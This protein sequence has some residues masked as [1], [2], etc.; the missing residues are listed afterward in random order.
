MKK[1]ISLILVLAMCLGMLSGCGGTNNANNAINGNAG[2]ASNAADPSGNTGMS[3]YEN[4]LINGGG[5]SD[6]SPEDPPKEEPP[7][8]EPEKVNSKA[9]SEEMRKGLTVSAEENAFSR[10]GQLKISEL[11][12]GKAEDLFKKLNASCIPVLDAWETDA[13]LSKD[14]ELPGTY[15]CEYDLRSAEIPEDLWDSLTVV[16]IGDDGS[17]NE[18]ACEVKDGKLIWD[19]S[20]NSI[21]VV[22]VALWTG[23]IV[24]EIVLGMYAY[25]YYTEWIG[26]KYIRDGYE[27]VKL[28]NQDSDFT[29]YYDRP[30]STKELKEMEE[31]IKKKAFEEAREWYKAVGQ[32]T[33]FSFLFSAESRIN[34]KA[35]QLM[36]EMKAEDK[37]Y[38]AALKAYNTIPADVK[39]EIECVKHARDFIRW[40][41]KA[42]PLGYKADVVLASTYSNHGEQIS[43]WIKRNYIVVRRIPASYGDDGEVVVEAKDYNEVLTTCTHEMFH[44][45]SAK[46]YSSLSFKNTTFAEM[47]ALWAQSEAEE[48]FKDTYY[49][50]YSSGE[51]PSETAEELG[52]AGMKY[53][54]LGLDGMPDDSIMERLK[55]AQDKGYA[56]YAFPV[57]IKNRLKS[58]VTPWDMSIKYDEQWG[59]SFEKVFT[60]TFGISASE[61]ETFWRLFVRE[62]KTKLAKGSDELK[63]GE[64]VVFRKDGKNASSAA[65]IFTSEGHYRVPLAAADYSVRAS[66]FSILNEKSAEYLIVEDPE[67][68]SRIPLLEFVMPESAKKTETKNGLVVS[69]TQGADDF[70]YILAVQGN[71]GK[72]A[73]FYDVYPIFAPDAPKAAADAEKKGVDVTLPSALAELP[74]AKDKV[75]DGI[76]ITIKDGETTLQTEKVPFSEFEKGKDYVANVPFSSKNLPESVDITIS[77]YT[78]A[79]AGAKAYEGPESK[80]TSVR[81]GAEDI[82]WVEPVTGLGIT[83]DMDSHQVEALLFKHNVDQLELVPR[84]MEQKIYNTYTPEWQERKVTFDI[85]ADP[86]IVKLD[87]KTPYELKQ[88]VSYKDLGLTIWDHQIP[89]GYECDLKLNDLCL[90][91]K[92]LGYEEKPGEV[93]VLFGTESTVTFGYHY[94]KFDS[95]DAAVI[96]SYVFTQGENN[97]QVKYTNEMWYVPKDGK[98][99]VKFQYDTPYYWEVTR[100]HIGGEGWVDP[101][102]YKGGSNLADFFE[103]TKAA[104]AKYLRV[105]PALFSTQYDLGLSDYSGY[106]FL[107]DLSDGAETVYKK[108]RVFININ[109]R[110][111]E[112]S[113]EV[114]FR[115]T[116]KDVSGG[117]IPQISVTKM[118]AYN[119]D[120][121]VV[122]DYKPSGDL[123]YRGH[124]AEAD[125]IFAEKF[126]DQTYRLDCLYQSHGEKKGDE[127]IEFDFH[128][129]EAYIGK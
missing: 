20:K 109:G 58:K 19:S 79:G 43:P 101:L 60:T 124:S 38:Q 126:D 59:K 16:R 52:L 8:E 61:L 15:H 32:Y 103:A 30:E 57:F 6:V 67:R 102:S 129:D 81:T 104:P 25:D 64:S 21:T 97:T 17:V 116:L 115:T 90:V 113:V 10:D 36:K 76:I 46:H 70:F 40:T 121:G 105:T 106:S 112:L 5:K 12:D 13:G 86:V 28:A 78:D 48:Y 3:D 125:R 55:P 39:A 27:I 77:E 120:G 82:G 84:Q 42:S 68:A 26:A 51:R 31:A 111:T 89:T 63:Y 14:E 119:T 33:S 110:S 2:N 29:F 95:K 54:A 85:E 72:A 123:I 47:T 1:C 73:S 7:A 65:T 108:D 75:T 37:E 99:Y 44:L 114:R 117:R 18:Y 87:T 9:F 71:G 98:L 35:A 45:Y 23:A 50:E 74:E 22:T 62:N 100:V 128:I 80:A 88:F 49:K 24:A 127:S 11:S 41:L 94:D 92:S 66:S 93:I 69:F 122:F 107:I 118:T 53:L 56:T 91:K 83:P 96:D 4:W 34:T